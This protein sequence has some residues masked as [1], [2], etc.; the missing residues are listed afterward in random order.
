MTKRKIGALCAVLAASAWLTGCGKQ[1]AAASEPLVLEVYDSLSDYEG[2]QKGW[3]ASLIMEKFNIQLKFLTQKEK[4]EK[5]LLEKAEEGTLPDL[6]IYSAQEGDLQKMAGEGNLYDMSDLLEGTEIAEYSDALKRMNEPIGEGGIYAIPGEVTRLAPETPS[7]SMS[8]DY[9]IY[10]RWDVYR[11]IGY[12]QI[13]DMEDLL[14]VMEEMQNLLRQNGRQDIYALSLFREDD[15]SVME[16]VSQIAGLFGYGRKGFVFAQAE[17]KKYK[18]MSEPD[19]WFAKTCL[20]LREAYHRGLLDPDSFTQTKEE[21]DAKYRDGKAFLTFYPELG[22]KY[23][24]S[25][26]NL[27]DNQGMEFAPVKGLKVLSKGCNPAGRQDRF[28]AIGSDTADPGR[29]ME[30]LN[31][32]YSPEGIMISGAGLERGTAGILGL[33]WDMEGGNPVLTEYGKKVFGGDNPQV[34]PEWGGGAWEEGVCQLNFRPV[35]EVEVCPSGFTYSYGIWDTVEEEAE[36][37][38]KQDWIDFMQSYDP[39][40]YLMKGKQLLVVPGYSV[41]REE[42]PQ[43][44]TVQRR[45][46]EEIMEDY[47]FRLVT[48][49]DEE[50]FD[51]LYQ[52]MDE[53]LKGNGY[54]NV[55]EYDMQLMEKQKE[56]RKK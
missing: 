36:A 1:E 26:G 42:E 10:L 19:S 2:L 51:T 53:K 32:F 25:S 35:V 47:F 34:P 14:D 6:I 8:A 16:H 45:N 56:L 37:S 40:E 23:S 55:L 54:E 17:E 21:A 11:Q 27:G 20:W 9:G 3:Y 41:Y 24:S 33:T 48:S 31:W 46:C 49:G 7:E 38:L 5:N 50:I 39:I 12:P 15:D 29:V 44:L 13:N 18:D 22:E 30:F 28:L 4:Q 43:S 52:E